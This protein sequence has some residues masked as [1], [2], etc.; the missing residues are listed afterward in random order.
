MLT[1]TPSKRLLSRPHI[2][3][4]EAS[5]PHEKTIW[6]KEDLITPAGFGYPDSFKALNPKAKVPVLTADNEV[7]TENPAIFTLI[8]QL[9][10]EKHLLGKT[11][12]ETV[13]V[14]EWL[15]YLSGTLHGQAYG[16]FFRPG[17]WTDAEDGSLDQRVLAKAVSTIKDS[18]KYV[19]EKLE[20]KK[21]AVGDDFTAV[22]AYLFVFY[23]WGVKAAQLPMEKDYPNYARLVGEVAKRPAVQEALKAEGLA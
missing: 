3:L 10:P 4:Q 20:G 8:S 13:R 2:L 1:R 15:N 16:M 19:E 9:A 21:W 23:Q 5:L 7:I 22:D 14:Y 18:Y 11:P 6:K 12:L 17:R